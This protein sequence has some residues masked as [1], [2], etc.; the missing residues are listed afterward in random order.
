MAEKQA[1]AEDGDSIDEGDIS[2]LEDYEG[3]LLN[4]CK[5]TS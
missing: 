5:S 1:A 2:G 4:P 3:N